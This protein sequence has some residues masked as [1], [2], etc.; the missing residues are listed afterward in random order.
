MLHGVIL[1]EG[2][3]S[4]GG[5]AELFAP[6]SVV[7]PSDGVAILPEHH[8]AV[9]TRAVPTREPDGTI[10]IAAR[11]MPAIFAAVQAGRR[12]MSVE[13][14]ALDEIRTAGGVREIRRAMVANCGDHAADARDGRAGALPLRRNRVR[15][16]RERRPDA[17][18]SRE[19]RVCRRREWRPPDPALH[20]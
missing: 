13:F 12:S 19:R 16:G 7:W 2:R 4:A 11:T 8:G 10:R 1:Q 20:G 18:A 6:Q 9:E 5:R 17:D 3:A 14:T 15:P